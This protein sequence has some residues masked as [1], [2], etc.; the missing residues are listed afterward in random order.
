MKLTNVLNLDYLHKTRKSIKT[1]LFVSFKIITITDLSTLNIYATVPLD[2]FWQEKY[3]TFSLALRKE[4]RIIQLSNY[5]FKKCLGHKFLSAIDLQP[6]GIKNCK[7]FNG[8]LNHI[9]KPTCSRKFHMLISYSFNNAEH[10]LNYCEYSRFK[11]W[12]MK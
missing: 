5:K 2:I 9:S 6:N 12:N 3:F 7:S 8:Q 4:H 11:K 10:S 1:Y